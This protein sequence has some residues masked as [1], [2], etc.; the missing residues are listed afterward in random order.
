MNGA[1]HALV[2]KKVGNVD[3]NKLLFLCA[4]AKLIG[5]ALNTMIPILSAI[6]NK[7]RNLWQ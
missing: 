5:P 7:M 2:F 1:S 3:K 6:R 4:V